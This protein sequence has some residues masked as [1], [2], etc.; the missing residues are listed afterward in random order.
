[1]RFCLFVGFAFATVCG[2]MVDSSPLY[3]DEE[4][5]IAN[6]IFFF[7]PTLHFSPLIFVR[8]KSTL[9]FCIILVSLLIVNV[10]ATRQQDEGLKDAVVEW[11]RQNRADPQPLIDEDLEDFYRNIGYGYVILY[12]VVMIDDLSIC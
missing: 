1:M 5:T 2:A 8:D 10:C 7:F 9:C 11:A 4:V 12:F 6:R 3:S